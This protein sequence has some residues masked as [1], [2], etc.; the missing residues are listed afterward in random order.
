[1]AVYH[2]AALAIEAER[3][4]NNIIMLSQQRYKI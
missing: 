2:N 4:L 1:M 3:I